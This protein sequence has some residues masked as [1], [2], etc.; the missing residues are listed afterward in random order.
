ME[1][2]LAPDNLHAQEK[3]WPGNV[4]RVEEKKS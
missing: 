2:R 4:G 3:L 1:L